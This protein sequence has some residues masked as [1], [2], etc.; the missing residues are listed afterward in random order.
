MRKTSISRLSIS[1]ALLAAAV[2]PASGQGN[3]KKL[4]KL[5]QVEAEEKAPVE[6]AYPL[7]NDVSLS[8]NVFEPAMQLF[9]WQ[10]AD[11]E[12]MLTADLHHRFMPHVVAGMGY[13]D[14]RSDDQVRFHTKATPYLKLGCYYNFKFNSPTP[15]DYYAVFARYGASSSHADISGMTYTDGYW[16]D[17][18]P[19]SLSRIHYRCHWLEVGGSIRVQVAGPLSLGWD[20]YVK[21]LIRKAGSEVGKP[22]FVPGYGVT[23]SKFGF[24]FHA[25]YSLYRAKQHPTH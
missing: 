10:H 13:C 16:P 12:A 18:G 9:G 3:P 4:L 1:L 14:E 24:G 20:L 22:Y 23:S 21:P 2:V 5:A 17:Y 11:Y 25:I 7:L 19:Q 8:V 6:Y 15:A